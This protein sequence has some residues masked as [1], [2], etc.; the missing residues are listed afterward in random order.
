MAW[1]APRTYVTGEIVTAAI[2]NADLR[3]NLLQTAPALVTT[4]GDIVVATAAN[5]L[6]RLAAMVGDVF[7]HE[8]GCLE[9]NISAITT[10]GMVVGT[11]SGTMAILAGGAAN[12]HLRVNSGAT[13][14][15]WAS[16][17]AADKAYCRITATG[18]LVA[19][20]LNIASITD[21]GTGDRTIVIGTDFANAN[22]VLVSGSADGNAM[23]LKHTIIGVGSAQLEIID[24]DNT[25]TLQDL[26][27]SSILNGDQ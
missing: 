16:P 12:Q 5:T 7:S 19:N 4:D 10:L 3:D 15:E 26:A 27:T 1:T 24:A 18:T 8:V 23:F 25:P 20:S 21:T 14:L 11:A 13:A 9:V 2:L 6:K 17:P 22:Y